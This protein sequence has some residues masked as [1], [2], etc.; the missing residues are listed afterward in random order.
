VAIFLRAASADNSGAGTSTTITPTLPA[1][2]QAGDLILI[3]GATGV[4]PI[5]QTGGSGSWT[6]QSSDHI[7]G[8][9]VLNSFVAWRV[10]AAS[11]TAPTFTAAG[12]SVSWDACIALAS[13]SANTMSLSI[14]VFAA[15]L[16]SG[17]GLTSFTPG[18]ATAAAA[19][20]A[21]VILTLSRAFT[22]GVATITYTPPAGW[23]APAAG[24]SQF[25]SAGQHARIAA[26][27][28]QLGLSG[29]VTPGAETITDTLSDTFAASVYHALVRELLIPDALPLTARPGQTWRRQFHHRQQPP[30]IR[31]AASNPLTLPGSVT[32]AASQSTQAAPVYTTTAT[33]AGSQS[34]QAGK[35][36]AA[37]ASAAGT[38]TRQAGKALSGAATAAGT[39]IRQAGKILP[40]GAAAAGSQSTRAGKQLAATAAATGALTRGPAR[41]LA[42][43]VTATGGL[44]RATG[45]TLTA[46]AT[47]TGTVL[48][49]IGRILAA[50]AS[51]VAALTTSAVRPPHVYLTQVTITPAGACAASV[52]VAATAGAAV[53]V[54]PAGA[55]AAAVTITV[56]AR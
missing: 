32:A 20:E 51:A 11:D 40:G 47:A 3:G 15:N 44:T 46:A 33:A 35:L 50:A 45:R 7:A 43:A 56:P 18:S 5:T 22:S 1:G 26:V 53:A 52:A 21:S 28:Y 41:L 4:L 10:M 2:W 36:A 12:T 55:S 24:Q 38:V 14:D 30:Q 25:S 48:R 34:A 19:G 37:T 49:G 9:G 16:I 6:I 13:T 23:T 54:T 29:T 27:A 31:P 42:A 8:S 39:L 17:T